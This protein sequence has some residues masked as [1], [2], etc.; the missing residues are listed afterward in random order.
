[1]SRYS[2]ILNK[3]KAHAGEPVLATEL[4]VVGGDLNRDQLQSAIWHLRHVKQE[5]IETINRGEAYK[6]PETTD[7]PRTLTV[8]GVVDGVIFA[9]DENNNLYE[10]SPI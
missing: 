7:V 10:V 4:Q 6:Y 5:P 2:D 1:M 9:R 8:Q 3:L